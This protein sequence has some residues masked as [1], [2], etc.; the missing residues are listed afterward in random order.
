MYIL[1]QNIVEYIYTLI[2]YLFSI[3][4]IFRFGHHL[5]VKKI[6]F[7][8]LLCKSD[9]RYREGILQMASCGADMIV[10]IYDITLKYFP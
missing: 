5:T 8:P 7:Q 4:Y 2:F 1:Y 6:Q 10:R 3:N 9:T